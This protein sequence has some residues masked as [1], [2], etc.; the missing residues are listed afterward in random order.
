[1]S[2]F[3]KDKQ[4]TVE[5]RLKVI[6]PLLSKTQITN[7]QKKAFRKLVENISLETGVSQR[8]IMRWYKAYD[9]LKLAG[10]KPKYPVVR[11]DKK[12]FISFDI[13][14]NE[15]KAMRSQTPTISVNDIIANLESRHPNIKGILKRSTVQEHLAKAGYSRAALLQ[16]TETSGR[17]LFGRYRKEHVLDQVQGDVKEPPRN[18]VVNEC[19]QYVVPYIHIWMDNHSR[20]ILTYR[21]DTTQKEDIALISLRLLIETYGIPD[22]ILTDQGSIYQGQAFRHCAHCLGITHRKTKPYTPMAKG[23]LERL[24]GSLDALLTPIK[25]MD[26]LKYDQ[27]VLMID[28]WVKEYN[29]KPHSAL[30]YTDKS[31][32]KVQMSPNQA[33]EL[34]SLNKTKR[35]P[36]ED[37]LN[38]AFLTFSS[39]RVSKD[40]TISFKG[41]LFKVS[42]Q[43]AKAGDR[44]TIMYCT[45][46]GKVSL[47]HKEDQSVDGYKDIPLFEH[48]VKANVDFA[49][50]KRAAENPY[51]KAAQALD[52][53]E[54]QVPASVE[55]IMRDIAKEHGSYQD[56]ESFKQ[57]LVPTLIY[58]PSTSEQPLNQ[59]LYSKCKES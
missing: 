3:D 15:A 36:P 22:S 51:N 56:E 20:K 10:L 4:S 37:I 21:V 27:F 58:T 59:S 57:G 50:R 55:R 8:T 7:E 35:Y 9:E 24:N 34:D 54:K 31:G 18:C 39:R 12:L 6:A 41:K 40:G 32:K 49:D 14:L 19:G 25:N 28:R 42:S 46:D 38:L 43:Y 16:L 5:Y 1:M 33:F 2:N 47:H 11:T 26:N 23:A 48:V 45:T 52:E 13:L 29:A 53:V 17:A 30:T 44:V